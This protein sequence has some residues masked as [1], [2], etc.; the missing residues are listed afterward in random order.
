MGITDVVGDIDLVRAGL[1][2]RLGR[3]RLAGHL[4]SRLLRHDRGSVPNGGGQT[5]SEQQRTTVSNHRAL[6]PDCS[7]SAV[8]TSTSSNSSRTP[9]KVPSIGTSLHPNAGTN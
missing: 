2:L 5:Q 3:Y 9:T 1:M 4:R 8:I 7:S 6:I